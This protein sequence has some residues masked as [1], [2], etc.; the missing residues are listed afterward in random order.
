M[1]FTL[2]R[3]M[4]D[5]FSILCTIAELN[6]RQIE[7][8]DESLSEIIYDLDGEINKYASQ[9]TPIKYV[10]TEN[11]CWECVSHKKD[12]YGYIRLMRKKKSVYLHRAVYEKEVGKIPDGLI[13]LHSCDNPACFNPEHLSVGTHYD[14]N[15][16]KISKGR[17]A[18]GSRNGRAK[19]TERDVKDI[20]N[21]D[22]PVKEI[23]KQ[24]GISD[25]MVYDIKNRVFWKHVD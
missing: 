8:D 22:R 6:K 23:A 4:C 25:V 17:Q 12:R 3:L 11:G 10:I 13:I 1:I 2:R 9:F 19:I 15:L 21:D 16:D 24:Y 14:N 20:R 7:E 18:K 5:K